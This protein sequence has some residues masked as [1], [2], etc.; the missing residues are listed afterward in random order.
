MKVRI[1]SKSSSKQ[2]FELEVERLIEKDAKISSLFEP[3][4]NYYKTASLF[5]LRQEEKT[6]IGS[7][8]L[9]EI[10]SDIENEDYLKEK[11]WSTKD[12]LKVKKLK[13]I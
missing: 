11:G 10:F 7:A 8:L 6:V 3:A 5:D 4:L 2:Q 1:E 12:I 13:Y 9:D